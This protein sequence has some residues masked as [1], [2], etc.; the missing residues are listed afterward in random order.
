M[1]TDLQA[2]AKHLATAVE[3]LLSRLFRRKLPS[4]VYRWRGGGGLFASAV[5]QKVVFRA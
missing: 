2:V 4:V 1:L 5:C 3:S